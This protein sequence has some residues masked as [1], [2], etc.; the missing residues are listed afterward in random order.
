MIKVSDQEITDTIEDLENDAVFPP[1]HII[2]MLQELLVARKTL[3]RLKIISS[4]KSYTVHQQD[5]SMASASGYCIHQA[6][7]EVIN[8]LADNF[9]SIDQ[10][11]EDGV[12]TIIASIYVL[13]QE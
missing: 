9:I 7:H 8:K 6:T 12:Y 2:P 11:S 10:L 13:E 5:H 4:S 3:K 1:S